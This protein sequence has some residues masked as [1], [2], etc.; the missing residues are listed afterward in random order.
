MAKATSGKKGR[1]DKVEDTL[2]SPIVPIEYAWLSKPDTKFHADGIY[3][4]TLVFSK[5]NAEHMAFLKQV[6]AMAVSI[7]G[8]DS[9]KLPFKADGDTYTMTVKTK[10]KPKVFDRR[11]Q[12]MEEDVMVGPGS[13]ARVVVKLAV[14]EGFGG[15]VTAYMNK[16]Q[17]VDYIPY[18]GSASEFQDEGGGD[19]GEEFGDTSAP[20]SPAPSEGIGSDEIP[21]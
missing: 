6:K 2:T 20:F 17:L 9:V 3:K 19:E 15:G 10:K 14:Y 18:E 7:A 13:T 12:L 1:K 11:A 8:D 16:I 4:A 5:G 21:F